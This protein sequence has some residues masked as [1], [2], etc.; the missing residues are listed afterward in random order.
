[1]FL[2]PFKRTEAQSLVS[3]SEV[4]QR[5]VIPDLRGLTPLASTI[6]SLKCMHILTHKQASPKETI[7]PAPLCVPC[8]SGQECLEL[9]LFKFWI[10]SAYSVA[11]VL[12]S[13][14]MVHLGYKRSAGLNLYTFKGI[15]GKSHSTLGK[16]ANY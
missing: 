10:M 9:N 3:I 8:P 6:H 1:M 5:P 11:R 15:Q 12:S 4:S 7:V 13:L 16:D 2:L 14:A